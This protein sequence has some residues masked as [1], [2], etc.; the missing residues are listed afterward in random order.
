MGRPGSPGPGLKRARRGMDTAGWREGRPFGF[1]PG[2]RASAA[3]RAVVCGRRGCATCA[4]LLLPPVPHGSSGLGPPQGASLRPGRL[5]ARLAGGPPRG[6]GGG[7]GFARRPAP[8]SGRERA[9]PV[10]G[11]FPLPGSRALPQAPARWRRFPLLRAPGDPPHG[12]G[13]PR[14]ALWGWRGEG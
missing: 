8:R 2:A 4:A 14:A 12:A 1:R 6:P 5:G 9:L 10:P 11:R 7:G 13:A 3:G